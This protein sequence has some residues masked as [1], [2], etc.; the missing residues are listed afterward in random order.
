MGPVISNTRV[1][2]INPVT[3]TPAL[4]GPPYM[5]SLELHNWLTGHPNDQ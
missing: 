1:M 3:T 4:D 5:A 2:I